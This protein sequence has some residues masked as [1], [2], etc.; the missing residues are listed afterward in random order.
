MFAMYAI[1][2]EPKAVQLEL[3]SIDQMY[4]LKNMK[5]WQLLIDTPYTSL[6]DM[7]DLEYRNKFKIKRFYSH[8]SD[9]KN[10]VECDARYAAK[11]ENMEQNLNIIDALKYEYRTDEA[12]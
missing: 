5:V 12:N 10:Y 7:E 3:D 4:Y 8:N 11:F 9:W 2:F 1:E 6:V